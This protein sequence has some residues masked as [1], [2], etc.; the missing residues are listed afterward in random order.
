MRDLHSLDGYRLIEPAIELW[1]WA[2][3]ETCGLFAV[4]SP[5]DRA[6]MRVV[7]SSDGGW[8]HVSVSRTNRCPNWP[9]MERVRKLFAADNETWVQFHV[10]ASEHVNMHPNCLHMWRWQG[11][12]LPKPPGIFVGVGTTPCAD[13]AEARERVDEVGL[14]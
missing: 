7:A 13:Y 14:S 6:L 11:G 3:D 4:P 1:G 5:T 2:G 10:P 9:E 8:D 12:E